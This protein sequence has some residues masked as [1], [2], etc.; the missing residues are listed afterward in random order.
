MS[1]LVIVQC[2][3]YFFISVISGLCNTMYLNNLR[4]YFI[5]QLVKISY[6]SIV[7]TRPGLSIILNSDNIAECTLS[8]TVSLF[9]GN[10]IIFHSFSG[11]EKSKTQICFFEY[12]C[13][14]L[15]I[16]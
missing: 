5:N 2:S 8:I 6:I 13:F 16:H 7:C 11:F 9:L 10:F 1:F 4:D 14:T 12:A 15:F 3:V